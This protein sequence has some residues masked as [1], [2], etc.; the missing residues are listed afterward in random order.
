MWGKEVGLIGKSSFSSYAIILMLIHY[1]IKAKKVNPILD[2]RGRKADA[3]HFKF[4][5][6]KANDIEQFDVYYN[7][8]TRSE[9][10]AANERVNYYEILQGF[11]KYYGY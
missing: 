8:K 11:M 10:V 4:K 6:M 9:D 1:L 3:P 2:A 7:Y 5:R